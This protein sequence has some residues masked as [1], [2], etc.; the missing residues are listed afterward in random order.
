MALLTI[1][2][3]EERIALYRRYS[4]AQ[5]RLAKVAADVPETVPP[6][7]NIEWEMMTS[8]AVRRVEFVITRAWPALRKAVL[9]DAQKEL[10][11]A[12]AAVHKFETGEIVNEPK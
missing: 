8:D 3:I 6:Q 5:A 11:D 12:E 10:D 9:A 2:Q 1:E 7:F 4:D